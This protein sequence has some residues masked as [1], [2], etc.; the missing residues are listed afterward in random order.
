MTD[1]CLLS[2]VFVVLLVVLFAVCY[3]GCSG[4]SVVLF[5]VCG[6]VCCLLFS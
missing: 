6:S 3:V 2:V 4:S 1:V 5:V